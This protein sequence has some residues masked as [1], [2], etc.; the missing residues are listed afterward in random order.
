MLEN[1]QD[2]NYHTHTYRCHHAVGTE[3]EYIEAAIKG[4]FKYLGFSEHCAYEN[5]PTSTSRLKMDEMDEYI[6]RIDA[7]KEKYKDQI[8]IRT[9]VEYEFFPDLTNYFEGLK[10]KFDYLI[11]GQHS[12]NRNKKD[13]DVICTDKDV[14]VNCDYVCQAIEKGLVD[15]LAHPDYFMLGRRTFNDVCYDAVKEMC[16]CAREY[17][18]PV[19]I[20]LKGMSFGKKRYRGGWSYIYPHNRTLEILAEVKPKIVLGYDAHNPQSLVEREKEAVIRQTCKEMG[21]PEPIKNL[22]L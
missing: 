14:K 21:L 5:W 18:V 7:C 16:I 19:E 15:Y 17:N 9:G 2:Y 10:A 1:L 12:V 11:L 22:R 6:S 3:E 13:V 4:G 8:T 20:N